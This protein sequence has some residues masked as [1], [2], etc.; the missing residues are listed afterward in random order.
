MES[1]ERRDRREELRGGKKVNMG[2]RASIWLWVGV[3]I[4]ILLLLVWLTVADFFG[5]TDVAAMITLF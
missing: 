5:D 4:L 3:G 1:Q 2:N